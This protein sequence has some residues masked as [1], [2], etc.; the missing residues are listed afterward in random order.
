MVRFYLRGGFPSSVIVCITIRFFSF[1]CIIIGI[2]TVLK[3]MRWK[4]ACIIIGINT[5]LKSMRWKPGDLLLGTN[6]NYCSAVCASE[7]ATKAYNI[8]GEH[9][10][11]E[12]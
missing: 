11:R 5:V 3:S 6:H 10:A 1:A 7:A 12:G 8:K 2:N 4:L 9:D